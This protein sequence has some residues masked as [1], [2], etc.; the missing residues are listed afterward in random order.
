MHASEMEI[1]TFST[2][3]GWMAIAGADEVL[4][5]L[6]FGHR[7]RSRALESIRSRIGEA[8]I[9]NWYPALVE[10]LQAYV[11][12][13]GDDFSNVSIDL[14]YATAFGMRVLE[15]C[16]RIP[17]GHT[18]SYRQ[19]AAQSGRPGAARA[20]GNCMA[21]NRCPIVVPCHRVVTSGGTLGRYS[22]PQGSKM[23]QRLLRLERASSL[24]LA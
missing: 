4:F 3:L 5:Q 10:R 18:I 23:K 12:G 21:A 16:R 17:F 14:C 19:L 22:A 2:E 1:A 7:S 6:S 20:V 9:A 15:A 11:D 8:R 13:S 24:Q